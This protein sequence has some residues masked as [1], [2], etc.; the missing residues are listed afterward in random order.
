MMVVVVEQ[1]VVETDHEQV[2][3]RQTKHTVPRTGETGHK[4]PVA[5]DVT[6][7]DQTHW[8]SESASASTSAKQRSSLSNSL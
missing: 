4:V 2:G 1:P 7:D 6:E 3:N 5:V 8:P